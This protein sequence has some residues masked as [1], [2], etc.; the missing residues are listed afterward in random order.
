MLKLQ[1]PHNNSATTRYSI[2]ITFGTHTKMIP[3]VRFL[4]VLKPQTVHRIAL[5]KVYK[6]AFAGLIKGSEKYIA[7]G[8]SGRVWEDH[9]KPGDIRPYERFQMLPKTQRKLQAL[10][11]IS[12][13]QFRTSAM[14]QRLVTDFAH[15]SCKIEHNRATLIEAYESRAQLDSWMLEL[16]FSALWF[17]DLLKYDFP[18]V[19]KQL[20]GEAGHDELIEIRNHV[21]TTKIISENAIRQPGSAGMAR[22]EVMALHKALVKDTAFEAALKGGMFWQ[23]ATTGEFRRLPITVVSH[24]EA[25]F[26]YPEELPA[27]FQR[28]LEWRSACHDSKGLHPLLF[29]THMFVYF[30]HLHPFQDGNGRLG[31]SIMADYIIRCGYLPVVFQNFNRMEYL[32]MVNEATNVRPERLCD[33]VL[34]AQAIALGKFS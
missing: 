33:A 13:T 19:K 5:E 28:F 4:E 7:L 16:G 29:G 27:L 1:H 3:S 32:D 17:S 6:K 22:D 11:R 20:Y 8:K 15:Q 30:V 10:K 9:H 14:I 26:P 2:Q 24:P 34:D 21:L 12:P 31:R 18:L 25:V 23:R